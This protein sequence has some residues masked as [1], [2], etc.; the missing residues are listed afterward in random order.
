[1][2]RMRVLPLGQLCQSVSET[3]HSTSCEVVLINTSD[4]LEG[5]VL[6]HHRVENKNLKGQFKK[7]FKKGDILYSEIRPQNKRYAYIDFDPDGYIA[8]TKLMVIRC[9][10]DNIQPLYLYYFL[11]SPS[12]IDH[13]QALAETRSGTFPQI[14][15]TEVANLQIHVPS[16]ECQN[17]IIGILKSIEDKIDVNKQL[18]RNLAR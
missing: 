2:E 7:S 14:T 12:I 5:L 6:N 11:T 10:K 3:F 18:N 8:S 4:V 17:K 1:M 13:L 9:D 16:L 15:F